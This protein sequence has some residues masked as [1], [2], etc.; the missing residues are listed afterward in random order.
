MVFSEGNNL[1]LP[2]IAG[3][4]P[5]MPKH[6]WEDRDFSRAILEPPV[7][8]GPYRIVG[9]DAAQ[10]AFLRALAQDRQTADLFYVC[11]AA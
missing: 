6:W 1:E 10:R 3:Q 7:G 4:M 2:L 8:S 9:T 5:I 11:A